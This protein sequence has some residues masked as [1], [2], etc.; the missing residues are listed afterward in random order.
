MPR[1]N[2]AWFRRQID[3]KSRGRPWMVS[4]SGARN[5]GPLN[6]NDVPVSSESTWQITVA[7]VSG[8]SCEPAGNRF[9]A[10]SDNANAKPHAAGSATI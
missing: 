3:T 5:P 1:G 4:T 2:N 9:K 7:D 10:G 6:R 8:D